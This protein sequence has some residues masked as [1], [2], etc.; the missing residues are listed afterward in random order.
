MKAHDSPVEDLAHHKDDPMNNHRFSVRP[1]VAAALLCVAGASHAGFSFST[2]TL[3]S[4]I[5][6]TSGST[7]T[8]SDLTIGSPLGVASTARAA[9][10]LSY[11]ASTESQLWVAQVSGSGGP[12]LT[13]DTSADTL[14]FSGF[15]SP[16]RAFGS[17]FFMTE[18]TNSSTLSSAINVKVTDINN[19]SFTFSYNQ[20]ASG[21]SPAT[22]FAVVSDAPLLSVQVFPTSIA[23]NPNVFI[24]ADNVVLS[25]VPEASTWAM[26]LAGGLAVLRIGRRRA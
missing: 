20:A 12:G 3:A 4:F 14:S 6:T 2:P 15:S 26:M 21:T 24:T 8:F 16:V 17:Q 13:V 11:A 10:S 23:G 9:G 18:L 7:D 1:L 19:L 5:T 25:A 22:F